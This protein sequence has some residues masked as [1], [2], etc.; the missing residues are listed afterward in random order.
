MIGILLLAAV[1]GVGL[2]VASG[3]KKVAP[4][5]PP[6]ERGYSLVGCTDVE[7]LDEAK[8]LKYAREQGLK[9]SGIDAL[10]KALDENCPFSEQL[11]QNLLDK[12]GK[13]AFLYRLMRAGLGG[14]VEAGGTLAWAQIGLGQFLAQVSAAGIDTSN[15]VEWPKGVP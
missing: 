9:A 14:Y 1:A 5:P 6:A 13:L 3:P 11:V 7:L 2:A 10:A 8:A 12:P 15:P 4:P